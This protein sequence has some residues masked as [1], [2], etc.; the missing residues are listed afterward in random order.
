V[1]GSGSGEGDPAGFSASRERFDSVIAFL[2]GATGAALSHAE[3]EERLTVQG[4]DLLRQLYQDHLDL[5][6]EREPRVDV[7]EVGGAARARV[8]P[9]H[10]R[11]LQTVF[12]VVQVHRLGYRAAGQANLYPVD[13]ELNLPVER[14]SHG[15]RQMAAV[16]AGRGSFEEA[17]A[18]IDRSSGQQLGKRQVEGL[19]GRA[20]ADFDDFYT[21]HKP[22]PTAEDSDVLVVQVDGKGIVMRPDALRPAT[23]RAADK[24]TP[25]LAGRLSKGEKGNRKR[26]AEVGAVH[27]CT[28]VVRTVA[29][30]L[31]ATDAER[32][33]ARAG[34]TAASKW[35]TASVVEDAA[36]VVA[37]VFDEAQRRDPTHA[38][39]WV[40]LV[41]GA[42]HQLDRIEAEAKARKVNVFVLIDVIHVLEYLWKA[43]WCFYP[44][45]DPHA[46]TWVHDKARAV[47]A[48]R[49]TGVAG[50]IRRTATNR[51][52]DKA[53]R[54]GAD[55][56]SRYLTNKARYLDYPTALAN[57][58]PIATGVIEGACRH[59]VKDR[60]D[61]TGAR[62][63]LQGAEAVLK[64]R[65]IRC[66]GDWDTYWTYH[67]A[68]ERRRVHESRYADNII[69]RAA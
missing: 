65:A 60:L 53:A 16:E 52:L 9:G 49:A 27:D 23:A 44:E 45:G 30:I 41:D 4:R 7:V 56:C 59:L 8:E 67:L 68:Q 62:W 31:P 57:G 5:R 47:L 18:A 13:G 14:H 37:Q 54:K 35:L 58:W 6:A 48:G 25:K 40:A 32:E 17:V 51:G 61:L 55:V 28:P 42:N 11:A 33:H 19:A 69:P 1:S 66:N 21:C 34:P 29:D 10:R 15:L 38:R 20:A 24:A 3:M 22:P 46:E 2:D 26:V 63:G 43:V 12:G 64:L 39:R 36:T 50:A